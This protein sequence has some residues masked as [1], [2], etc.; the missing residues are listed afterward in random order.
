[1][2]I[3]ILKTTGLVALIGGGLYFYNKSKKSKKETIASPPISS[4]THLP[5]PIVDNSVPY[6]ASEISVKALDTIAKVNKILESNPLI[7]PTGTIIPTKGIANPTPVQLEQLKTAWN[8]NIQV[9][10]QMK[11]YEVKMYA[12][13][14]W[15]D[16]Y[17]NNY[18]DL[19]KYYS[20][21]SKEKL[22]K[23]LPLLP[24]IIASFLVYDR[25]SVY[26]DKDLILMA[27]NG[28]SLETI[29][30]YIQYAI[31]TFSRSI[32]NFERSKSTL[33]TAQIIGIIPQQA[34][35]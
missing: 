17:Q 14:V 33:G 12:R 9:E 26:S 27:D 34:N 19:K 25:R 29:D 28:F 31:P 20:T 1:M 18:V 35:L 8:N 4:T 32:N 13:K 15:K 3:D 23:L 7:K 24:M 10:N 30:N 16:L 22:D 2:K 11:A 6:S 21:L 5:T